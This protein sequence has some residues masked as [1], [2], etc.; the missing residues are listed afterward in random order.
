MGKHRLLAFVDFD[1]AKEEHA[2]AIARV[3]V[4]KAVVEVQDVSQC[5]AKLLCHAHHRAR[6]G[7]KSGAPKHDGLLLRDWLDCQ[8]QCCGGET[9]AMSRPDGG[10]V[11]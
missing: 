8:M 10:N 11:P 2:V 5:G 9:S 3:A 7:A 6:R 4:A 1:S